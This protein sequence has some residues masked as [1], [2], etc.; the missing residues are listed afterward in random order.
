[1]HLEVIQK[2]II[3][4]YFSLGDECCTAAHDGSCGRMHAFARSLYLGVEHTVECNEPYST[5]QVTS[6]L[7]ASYRGEWD[8]K[9]GYEPTFQHAGGTLHFIESAPNRWTMEGSS[10]SSCLGHKLKKIT[11]EAGGRAEPLKMD[12]YQQCICSSGCMYA[13]CKHN[14]CHYYQDL[15]V[16]VVPSTTG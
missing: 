8:E 6:L 13:N 11:E 7:L 9:I 10:A 14:E 3:I 16:Y 15:S 1:M 2:H 12:I 5:K 4:Y